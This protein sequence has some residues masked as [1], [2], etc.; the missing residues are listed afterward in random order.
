MSDK[1]NLLTIW[2][3]SVETFRTQL[4]LATQI[5]TFLAVADVTLI[6]YATS[7]KQAALIIIGTIFPVMILILISAV[8]IMVLPIIFTAINI[9]NKLGIEENLRLASN[10]MYFINKSKKQKIKEAVARM[11][12]LD[13]NKLNNKIFKNIIGTTTSFPRLLLYLLIA[14][15][16]TAPL[17]LVKYFGWS[18]I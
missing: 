18:I 13:A 9:E 1:S 7:E 8:K 6:G 10:Y 12:I 15:Q 14:L 17:A 2:Q 5:T 4:R 16:L 11:S 3:E